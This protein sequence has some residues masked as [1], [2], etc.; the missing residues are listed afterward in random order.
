[1]NALRAVGSGNKD[2]DVLMRAVKAR[3]DA[4]AGIP[5][6]PEPEPPAPKN[7]DTRK[8]IRGANPPK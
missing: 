3:R 1:M 5:P 8:N 4:A 2:F 6:P 7:K